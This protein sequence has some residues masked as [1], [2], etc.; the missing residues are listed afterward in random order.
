[1][2]LKVVEVPTVKLLGTAVK[3]AIPGAL[4]GVRMW[5]KRYA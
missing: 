2:T 4:A 1:M 3:E 5:M